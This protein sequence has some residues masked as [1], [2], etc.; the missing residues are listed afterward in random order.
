MRLSAERYEQILDKLKSDSQAGKDRRN[1]PRVG[2]PGETPLV[3]VS[4]TGKRIADTVRVR[5]V[6][7]RGIGLI[8]NQMLPAKQRFMLQLQYENGKP[9][10]LVCCAT[11][12][13]P[14]D[15]GRF[16]VGARVEQL[17]RADQIHKAEPCAPAE[18]K[19]LEAPPAGKAA[20]LS[21]ADIAR[22]SKAIL[23]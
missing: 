21:E 17:L 8:A 15:G 7:R 14:I 23:G 3:G 19:P 11:N 16:V 6:S 20:S 1:E 18:Q 22:I 12:C 4:Q 10:W 5:D 9:L 2:L 13:R